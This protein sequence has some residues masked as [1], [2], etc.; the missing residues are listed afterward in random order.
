MFG[1]LTEVNSPELIP[2][3]FNRPMSHH[4]YGRFLSFNTIPNI[5]CD[6]FEIKGNVLAVAISNSFMFKLC[7]NSF[8]DATIGII[9]LT[10]NSIEEI[11]NDSF[12]RQFNTYF[13]DLRNNRLASLPYSDLRN[14]RLA[15]LPYSIFDDL[16]GWL[17]LNIGYNRLER[18]HENIFKRLSSL[19]T[20][21]LEHNK[22]LHIS[23]SMLP[24]NAIHFRFLNLNQN[25]FTDFPVSVLYVKNTEFSSVDL[26]NMNIT[27]FNFSSFLNSVNLELLVRGLGLDRLENFYINDTKLK[28]QRRNIN[29]MSCK[30]TGFIIS[31]LSQKEETSLL[32][33]LK[34]FHFNLTNNPIGC[35][36][37]NLPFIKIMNSFKTLGFFTGNEYFFREWLC[38][39]P[40]KYQGKPLLSMQPNDMFYEI[41]DVN[42]PIKCDCYRWYNKSINIVDCNG[43]G[44]TE[45]PDSVPEGIVDIWID[46]NDVPVFEF[47]SY[48]RNVRQL[49]ASN[50][51]LQQIK[52][53]VFS[54]MKKMEVLKIDHNQL[55][56]LPTDIENL[57][58]KLISLDNNPLICD[59][60]T[61]WLKTWILKNTNAVDNIKHITCQTGI[62]TI[63]TL[64]AVPDSDF[65]C[66]RHT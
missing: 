31:E 52:P 22:L 30:V 16:R 21:I 50:I 26:Q 32:T 1:N 58:L 20:L 45:I 56:Y 4:Q 14:N 43:K 2:T 65:I 25:M 9:T 6:Q 35:F 55:L 44:L 59:C 34:Y 36:A 57:N 63:E 42:C 38:R 37:V 33:L 3:F 66:K 11:E 29:L 8:S 47:R 19:E 62:E 15:S 18:L 27:F 10:N 48:F 40:Q 28:V 12:K 64:I 39:Y 46:N 53:S 7:S 24:E 54:R 49:F 5:G 13:L 60:H 51:S 17:F 61:V 23:D 41:F